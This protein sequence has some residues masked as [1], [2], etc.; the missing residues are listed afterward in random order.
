MGG[1]CRPGSGVKLRAQA[2]HLFLPISY[3]IP[4]VS[5]RFL[6]DLQ[7]K[8]LI[9]IIRESGASH[10]SALVGHLRNE[11]DNLVSSST[12]LSLGKDLWQKGNQY[13]SIPGAS[14]LTGTARNVLA[15]G[16]SR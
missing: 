4:R 5:L 8:L 9:C 16:W 3:P 15:L 7:E 1:C 11:V 10:S 13:G 2:H 6:P 12:C 14:G